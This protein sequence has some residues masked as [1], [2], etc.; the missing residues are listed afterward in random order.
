MPQLIIVPVNDADE[1]F[2]FKSTIETPI[3]LGQ[4]ESILFIKLYELLS[5]IHGKNAFPV[6]GVARGKKSS[7]ANKWNQIQENDV[8]IFIRNDSVIGYAI[9]KIKFQSENVAHQL[10]PELQIDKDRQYLFTLQNFT[11]CNLSEAKWFGDFLR[12]IKINKSSFDV[13]EN[14]AASELVEKLVS[15][16]IGKTQ[17]PPGQGFGLNAAEK[18]VI[19]KHAMAMAISYLSS[20]GFTQITD[21]GDSESYDIRANGPSQIFCFEVKGST[22]SG[23]TIILTKNEVSIQKE[24]YPHNGLVVVS[25]IE[26]NRGEVLSVNGGNLYFLSP[27]VID[28]SRLKA[29]SY[30]YKVQN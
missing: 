10:W 24:L 13:L 29:I 20:T 28:E 7:E 9:V 3:N 2:M 16:S 21:V 5:E 15:F 12:K 19:E 8:A 11:I 18:K 23:E 27:W 17:I 1:N 6:W 22:G 30:D 25:G 4:L 26:L 14:L